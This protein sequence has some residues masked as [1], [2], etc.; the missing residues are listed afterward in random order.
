MKGSKLID[1]L[2]ALS[3]KELKKFGQYLESPFLNANDKATE[4][5]HI[6]K[7]HHP[8][9]SPEHISKEQVHRQLFG[10]IPFNYQQLRHP[11]SDLTKVLEEYLIYLEFKSHSSEQQHLLAQSYERRSLDKHFT[12]TIHSTNKIQEA[13]QFKDTSYYHN[14][15]VIEEDN[16]KF[17]A[18]RD[19]RAIDT[20]LQ[21][22]S[23]NIDIHFL[24]RKL[25]YSCEI[26]NRMNVLSVK[27]DTSFLDAVIAYLKKHSYEEVPAIH[28][29]YTILLTLQESENQDHYFLLK[30]ML[31]A[32][33]SRFSQ[34]EIRDMYAFLQ[35][36]CIRQ[37][38]LGNAEFLKE[39]FEAYQVLLENEIIFESGH[40]SQFDF[41]NIVTVALRLEEHVWARTFI[42]KDHLLLRKD[43]RTNAYTYNMARLHFAEGNYKQ[44][45]RLL[46][47]VEF[48][49]V[50]YHLDSKALLL[51]T[52]YELEDFEPLLSL[53]NTFKVYL[54]RNKLISEYQRTIYKNMITIVK[55]F[56]RL[57]LGRKI[58][59]QQIETQMDEI[60]QMADATWLKQKLNAL[61]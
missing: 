45:L 52:Y 6:L 8:E 18:T 2:A 29:Y 42:E 22:L 61:K 36:Y 40:I 58:T 41:K 28:I 48:T 9:F 17:T 7:P 59:V 5:F 38:N 43:F 11:M 57:K 34:L 24:T 14:Q 31:K 53:I 10:N 13:K 56:S 51:K 23:D 44:S 33:I 39:L 19:N 20:S 4:L 16:Y 60:K 25:K 27:Y 46:L 37:A 15:L 12:Q 49:D 32:N 54:K 3:Y 30:S 26:I 47:S 55:Q 1:V 21:Q 35:N 50:Y